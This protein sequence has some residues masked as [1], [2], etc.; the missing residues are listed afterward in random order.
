MAKEILVIGDAII[1]AGLEAKDLLGVADLPE[2]KNSVFFNI[3]LS[4]DALRQEQSRADIFH[5]APS[6][7]ARRCAGAISD[8]F[9]LVPGEGHGALRR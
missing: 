2:A 1:V 8:L 7:A 9:T 6:W 5:A 3:R 4:D